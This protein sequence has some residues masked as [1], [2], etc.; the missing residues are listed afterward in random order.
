MQHRLFSPLARP[1]AVRLATATLPRCPTTTTLGV[2]GGALAQLRGLHSV[3]ELPYPVKEGLGPLF[4]RSTL[5]MLREYQSN[6]IQNVNR[7]TANT[8][9]ENLS[10]VSVAR[11]SSKQAQQAAIFNYASQA[12][13]LD[14]FLTTLQ[15]NAAASPAA[16][17]AASSA[18]A[19][20]TLS[21]LASNSRNNSSPPIPYRLLT[22]I[23]NDYGTQENFVAEFTHHAMAI[24][25]SGWTWLVQDEAGLLRIL[26]TYNA[27]SVLTPSRMDEV[28]GNTNAS[29][30]PTTSGAGGLLQSS[31]SVVSQPTVSMDPWAT[32]AADPFYKSNYFVNTGIGAIRQ[33]GSATQS[34]G[35]YIPL[36][37]LNMWEH[38]YL[39]DHKMDKQAYI[40]HFF[41]HVN[42][43]KVDR[44]YT[45]TTRQI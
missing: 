1:G 26:N 21:N 16:T 34:S 8:E 11:K 37:A 19:V 40:A 17:T 42:W 44:R 39:R 43:E 36:L 4:S 33:G 2:G 25:G 32:N 13:N 22:K 12:W 7:L 14:F 41:N 28:D 3:P 5:V 35:E 6:L 30:T 23:E 9:Y 45:T 15:A 29:A 24:F 20:P 18:N 31:E 10:L 38:A 27:G